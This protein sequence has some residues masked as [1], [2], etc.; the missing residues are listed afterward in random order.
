MKKK[1]NSLFYK[2]NE[3]KEGKHVL[4]NGEYKIK[5]KIISNVD[6]KPDKKTQDRGS[7]NS[8]NTFGFLSSNKYSFDYSSKSGS[9]E[10]GYLKEGVREIAS[11]YMES[12]EY[13]VNFCKGYVD[14][15]FNEI[16][17]EIKRKKISVYN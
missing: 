13:L 2:Q 3:E 11:Q 9:K 12:E 6:F 4:K 1:K 8:N 17:E 10:A 16:M 7:G 5:K 15:L 14:N